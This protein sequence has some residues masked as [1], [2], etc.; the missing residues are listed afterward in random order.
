MQTTF[1][2]K[3]STTKTTACYS[4]TAC[5]LIFFSKYHTTLVE[6]LAEELLTITVPLHHIYIIRTKVE[7]EARNQRKA[8]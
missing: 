8:Q 6:D 2:R 3:L 5:L 4:P 7:T 1:Q